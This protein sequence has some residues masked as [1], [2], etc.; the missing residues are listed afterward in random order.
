[1]V[2]SEIEQQRAFRE[3]REIMKLGEKWQE[4][5]P[6]EKRPNFERAAKEVLRRA[7]GH[8][9]QKNVER[10]DI[11]DGKLMHEHEPREAHLIERFLRSGVTHP[12][13]LHSFVHGDTLVDPQ[14]PEQPAVDEMSDLPDFD[15]FVQ[16]NDDHHY[17]GHWHPGT[18][19]YEVGHW[20]P[21]VTQ[22]PVEV[23]K[24]VPEGA[25]LP[26]SYE[27]VH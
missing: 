7:L 23:Q 19:Q 22:A 12:D 15:V 2:L 16:R 25:T 4:L 1:M 11:R 8:R 20:H 6:G 13:V 3:A 14:A 17:P 21:H 26:S 24:Q 5:M 18:G 10:L 9:V 27:A